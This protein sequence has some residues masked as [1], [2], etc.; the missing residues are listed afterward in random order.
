M[1]DAPIT[2][3]LSDDQK[4]EYAHF[5]RHCIA[6]KQ[7]KEIKDKLRESAPYRSTLMQYFGEDFKKYCQFY[8]DMPELVSENSFVSYR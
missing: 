6:K 1:V 4:K 2:D 5:F 3:G 7:T 8:L